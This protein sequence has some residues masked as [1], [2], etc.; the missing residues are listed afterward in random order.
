M[1]ACMGI[2]PGI[3]AFRVLSTLVERGGAWDQRM[4]GAGQAPAGDK[5]AR[6]GCSAFSAAFVS[7]PRAG[8]GE[9]RL[10]GTELDVTEPVFQ[11][12]HQRRLG[13]AAQA[14][15]DALADDLDVGHS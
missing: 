15:V 8:Q 2:E 9:G 13:A 7:P 12:A 4:F 1:N 6:V 3:Y 14:A 5:G 11:A 10:L